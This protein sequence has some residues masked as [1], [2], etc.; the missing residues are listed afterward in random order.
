MNDL[1]KDIMKKFMVIGI[2]LCLAGIS[3]F[4]QSSRD[5]TL[6]KQYLNLPVQNDAEWQVID[7]IVDGNIVRTL[8]IS[9]ADDKTDFWTFLDVSMFEN[10]SGTLV[11]RDKETSPAGFDMIYQDDLLKE[12]A[13]IYKEKLRPQFH[14]T[15]K[16]GWIQDP[17]GLVYYEGEYHMFP[18]HCPYSWEGGSAHHWGHAVS[19]DLIHWEEI[20]EAMFPDKLGTM[21]AGS[22]VIDHNNTSGFQ[23]GEEKV[24]VAVYSSS[25]Q[26]QCLAYSSDRGR[27]WTKYEGNPFMGDRSEFVG[28]EDIRDPKVF[29]YEPTGNWVMVLFEGVGNSIFTSDNL[30]DWKYESHIDNSWECPELF[31]LP[32]NGDPEN[33][34]WVMYG[35]AGVYM[36]GDFDGKKF[37]PESGKLYY[38]TG[39]LNSMFKHKGIFYASQTFNEEP[40]GRRIQL[41]WGILPAPGMP[42]NQMTTFP[43]ELS[44]KTTANG[45]RM[46][47]NPIEEIELL[48]NKETVLT[49][50]R[51]SLDLL[52]ILDGEL[53]ELL[54]IKAEFEMGARSSFGVFGL[55]INGFEIEYD[56]RHNRLN[57]A[58]LDFEDGK[59]TL[60]IL[61]DRTSVEIYAN[62]GRL[63]LS[64]PHNST[65]HDKQL[66]LYNLWGKIHLSKL[67]IYELDSIWK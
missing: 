49:D 44:L 45:I 65:E 28:N 27:T 42:F 2:I 26:V 12:E 59:I 15:A 13:S 7:L 20:Q 61:M 21:Y 40:R 43:N 17:V 24:M 9:L 3:L 47:A 8:N 16:R 58:F 18:I 29:W 1:S 37:T 32:V 66:D 35:A 60:E 4:A 55:R 39:K 34:K 62:G 57:D 14:F 25:S 48:H 10:K 52:K 23:T 50:L 56:A 64:D 22:M 33:T 11:L 46:F 53:G 67:E 36:I 6:E 38:S 41:G 63:Y 19:R 54:H 51:D 30:M 5:I 31:E